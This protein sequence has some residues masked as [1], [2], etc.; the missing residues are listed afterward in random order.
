MEKGVTKAEIR[1]AKERR[2]KIKNAITIVVTGIALIGALTAA[3][4][5]SQKKSK[6]NEN[7]NAD[8]TVSQS[9][10]VDK[11]RNELYSQG[12]DSNGMISGIE[13]IGDYVKLYD[14]S[15]ITLC[16]DDFSDLVEHGQIVKEREV[17]IGEY[18]LEKMMYNSEIT[19][20]QPYYDILYSQYEFVSNKEFEGYNEIYEQNNKEKWETI[21][22]F[23]GISDIEYRFRL[24]SNAFF[25]MR[26][27]LLCQALA[28]EFNIEL[29]QQDI[30][31]YCINTENG[32]V[33][34]YRTEA[35]IAKY[36]ESFTKQQALRYKI[37]RY[38][39]EN[40]VLEEG[41]NFESLT[42]DSDKYS[43]GLYESG[44]I[45]GVGNIFTY[46]TGIDYEK[47]VEECKSGEDAFEYIFSNAKIDGLA[48]YESIV[49]A[50]YGVT[51]EEA[52]DIVNRHLMVQYLY[53][54]FELKADDFERD[55]LINKGLDN[56]YKEEITYEKGNAFY[57]REVMEYSVVR[58][59][60]LLI[61]EKNK[62]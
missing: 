25:E 42:D 46:C 1:K 55:Y 11:E 18:I 22:S 31:D 49:E 32:Y 59:L 41:S 50:K 38:L 12:I 51:P 48:A 47:A 24:N 26:Y 62:E 16:E 36:G 52:A 9:I 30:D 27:N 54:E 15:K 23:Y 33:E 58:Y 44:K 8:T 40:A 60:D 21:Q 4:V 35:V 37:V 7:N 53:T 56:E 14:M 29:T 5:Y 13:N 3:V 61:D 20:Y 10:I 43:Q 34:E 6:D 57:N 28:E 2:N 45:D 17:L 39:G 19:T